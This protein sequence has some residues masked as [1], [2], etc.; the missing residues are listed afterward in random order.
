MK[1]SDIAK[2]RP[3][4]CR[5]DGLDDS[6]SGIITKEPKWQEDP[7]DSAKEVLVVMLAD[8]GLTYELRVRSQMIDAVRDAVAAAWEESLEVGGFLSVTFTGFKGQLKLYAAT[9]EPPDTG[10]ACADPLEPIGTAAL[11]FGSDDPGDDQ[12]R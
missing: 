11:E 4:I 1:L 6:H 2:G 10:C 7:Y 5:F 8:K 3:V 12:T 9:Y